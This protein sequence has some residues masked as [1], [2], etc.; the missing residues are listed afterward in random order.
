MSRK[1]VLTIER[2]KDIVGEIMSTCTKKMNYEIIEYIMRG[3]VYEKKKV[4][5]SFLQEILN[6][7][8]VASYSNAIEHYINS[9]KFTILHFQDKPNAGRDG[10]ERHERVI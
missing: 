6:A 9:N 2:I 7:A 5:E 1:A 8:G 3:V 10:K 4:R